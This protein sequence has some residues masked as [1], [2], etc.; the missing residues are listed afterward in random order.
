MENNVDEEVFHYYHK[1]NKCNIEPIWGLRFCCQECLNYDLCE[2]LK[3]IK[4]CFDLNLESN[5]KF[6]DI[7]HECIFYEFPIKA[8][9]L[10]AHIDSKYLI[11]FRCNGCFM[12]PILGVCFKCN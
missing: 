5:E 8:D 7:T 6:H 10:P 2:G 4:G 3:I 12:K 9:G 11:K 1:C